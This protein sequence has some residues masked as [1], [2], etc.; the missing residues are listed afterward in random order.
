M[1]LLYSVWSAWV[2]AA[3]SKPADR[4]AA[5]QGLERALTEATHFGFISYQYEARLALGEIELASGQTARGRS[6]LDALAREAPGRGFGLIAR[7]AL[8]AHT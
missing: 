4:A 2:L 7:K 1:G 6:R 3:S 5:I 8:R